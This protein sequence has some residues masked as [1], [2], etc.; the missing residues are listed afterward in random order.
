V[1]RSTASSSGTSAIHAT[2]ACPN[3]GKLRARRTPE[4]IARP[5]ADARETF[6]G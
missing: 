5:N 1:T 2:A 4:R 6:S 3:F